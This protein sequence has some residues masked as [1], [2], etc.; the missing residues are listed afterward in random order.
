MYF[1]LYILR[2]SIR[3]AGT[4]HYV[5]DDGDLDLRTGK[6]S[7]LAFI[8]VKRCSMLTFATRYDSSPNLHHLQTAMCGM[9]HG[10]Q[11]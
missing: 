8:V 1:R 3:L 5:I 11:S 4:N 2:R 9:G 6:K 10:P 7:L